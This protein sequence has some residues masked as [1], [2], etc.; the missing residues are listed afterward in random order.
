MYITLASP[1]TALADD[2]DVKNDP[3]FLHLDANIYHLGGDVSYTNG[4]A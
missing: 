2:V 1:K 4:Q 3:I